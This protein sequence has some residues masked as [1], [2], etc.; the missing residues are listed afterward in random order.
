MQRKVNGMRV[1]KC[2]KSKCII[3]LRPN[4][5]FFRA[6]PLEEEEKNDLKI[7][8]KSYLKIWSSTKIGNFCHYKQTNK[9]PVCETSWQN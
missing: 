8:K 7:S 6:I 9:K 4:Y 2:Y 5:L 1:S 3:K